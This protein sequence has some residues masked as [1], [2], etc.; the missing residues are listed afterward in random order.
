MYR[1]ETPAASI[2]IGKA[3]GAALG[4]F[5]STVVR[6]AI[7]AAVIALTAVLIPRF[8]MGRAEGLLPGLAD[9]P[10]YLSGA[11]EDPSRLLSTLQG[12]L[13][14]LV[15]Q[16]GLLM[17]LQWLI[18]TVGTFF[19]AAIA[20]DGL[21]GGR[22]S[23]GEIVGRGVAGL[24]ASLIVSVL[25]FLAVI[26]LLVGVLSLIVTV[27]QVALVG[28]LAPAIVAVYLQAR[29]SFVILAAMDGEGLLGSIGASWRMSADGVL[30]VIGWFI[31]AAIVVFVVGI[32][33]GFVAAI[34][35]PI[36]PFAATFL[37]T[38]LSAFLLLVT[39]CL[40]ESQRA[41]AG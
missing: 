41:R 36:G 29:T 2:S 26:L 10:S 22:L 23:S 31:V 8:L 9:L 16:A 18:T 7:P 34:A 38:A 21:R 19:F 30:R 11:T 39:A 6:W 5:G 37:S 4:L 17:V 25:V 33:L 3:Y 1:F 15:G 12:E 20:I 24:V 35:D 28:L 40:Y 13:S 27:G 32:P 14:S